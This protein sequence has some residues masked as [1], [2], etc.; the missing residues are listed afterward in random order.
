MRKFSSED[1]R[2]H[3]W[4][5]WECATLGLWYASHP[6]FGYLKATTKRKLLD[7]ID[8]DNIPTC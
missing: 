6:A 8:L 4:T 2:Q 5:L 3:G 1:A 7:R